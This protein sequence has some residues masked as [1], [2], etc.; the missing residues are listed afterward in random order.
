[1]AFL[2]TQIPK[3]IVST[4][5]LSLV[6]PKGR[7]SGGGPARNT[8]AAPNTK[9]TVRSLPAH[10][11]NGLFGTVAPTGKTARVRTTAS[12]QRK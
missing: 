2:S 1:M 9:L 7:V 11:G 8:A 10:L 5:G 3:S 12:V 4:R 6:K